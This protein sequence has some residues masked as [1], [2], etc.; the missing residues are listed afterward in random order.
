M[1]KYSQKNK[2]EEI[3]AVI[4][5]KGML[6]ADE[7]G[8]KKHTREYGMQLLRPRMKGSK[9]REGKYKIHIIERK[10]NHK[11]GKSIE[12]WEIHEAIDEAN[13]GKSPGP[14]GITAKV[15]KA[16]KTT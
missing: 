3:G 15:Y 12:I 14:D 1:N 5:D 11:I 8:V 16:L 4:D 9:K 6:H 13:C 10:T 2:R 7:E